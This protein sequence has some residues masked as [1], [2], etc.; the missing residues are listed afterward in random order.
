MN[1]LG[2]KLCAAFSGIFLLATVIGFI[3]NPLV[4]ANAIFETNTAHNLVHLATALGFL[5]VALTGN[6]ASIHFMLGFGVVYLLV[7]LVGFGVTGISS[8]GRLLGFVQINAMDNFLHLGLGAA[9]LVS[10][11]VA[12]GSIDVSSGMDS[13]EAPQIHPR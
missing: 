8:G 2:I 13:R 3:P 6:R 4:G 7:G 10:G 5:I 12:K 1:N 11:L 9:I